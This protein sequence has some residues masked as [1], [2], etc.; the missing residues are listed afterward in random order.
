MPP[1]QFKRESS[2]PS[3]GRIVA[4]ATARMSSSSSG[5]T[6]DLGLGTTTNDGHFGSIL[7]G[8]DGSG[9]PLDSAAAAIPRIT[10]TGATKERRTT[11]KDIL[12]HEAPTIVP[13][14]GSSVVSV[15][16][17]SS[18]SAFSSYY[19][20]GS[21]SSASSWSSGI[22]TPINASTGTL[23]PIS[24]LLSRLDADYRYYYTP[25]PTSLVVRPESNKEQEVIVK[26][27]KPTVS[28]TAGTTSQKKVQHVKLPPKKKQV[29]ISP[30]SLGTIGQQPINKRGGG[31]KVEK[32]KKPKMVFMPMIPYYFHH[33]LFGIEACM[34]Q[35]EGQKRF[36]NYY[37]L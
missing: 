22:K 12:N 18:S 36:N 6:P 34:L 30:L 25:V 10:S 14:G 32:N 37:Y 35:L 33:E 5:V 29:K 15:A 8:I 19:G 31:N 28:L 13:S 2:I 9:L 3:L 7:S 27:E 26:K 1:Q 17:S 16:S 21:S 4:A 11:N 23:P 24:S 20:A